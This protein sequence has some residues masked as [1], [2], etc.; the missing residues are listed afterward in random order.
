VR[1]EQSVFPGPRSPNVPAGPTVPAGNAGV[2]LPGLAGGALPQ[3]FASGNL[4]SQAPTRRAARRCAGAASGIALLALSGWLTGAHLLAGQWGRAIPM[5]PATAAAFL[6]LSA[7][8]FIHARWPARRLNPYVAPVSI[9]IPGL[10]GLLALA[11]FIGGFDLGLER[12]LAHTNQLLGGVP[13]GRMSPLAAAA[14]LLESGAL[15]LLLRAAR[16]RLAASVAALLALAAAAINAAIILGY[17]YGAPLL[18]GGSTIPVALPT[19]LAF[20]LVGAGQIMLALPAV[21]A[22]RAWSGDSMRG[23]LLRAF[24]PAIL[25]VI[26]LDGWLDSTFWAVAFV[27]HALWQSLTASV[28]CILIVTIIA[29]TARRTGDALERAKAESQESEARFR[30][31]FESAPV[32]Y[33]ELDRDGVVRRVNAAECALLGYQ[34]SEM[35][36]RAAWSLVAKA[37][38]EA[39]RAAVFRKLAGTQPLT[40]VRRR[41]RRRDGV[42]LLLEIHDRLVLSQVGEIQGLR[43]AFIDVTEV[44]RAEERIARQL[45]DLGAARDAQEK[46]GA[47]LAR[48]VEEL[49]LEKDRAQD[50]TRAKSE[51][52]ANMSHEIRTPMNG[53][54]GMTG[55][56]LD[57][58]LS[59]EQRGYAGIVR[60]SGESL[61]G[62]INDILDF[63][64]M[65]A[66]KLDL[67]VLDFCLQSLLDDFAATLGV[68][69]QEKGL[70]LCCSADPGVPTRLRGDPGRLRQILNNLVGNAVKFTRQGEVAVRVSLEEENETACLLRF[71]VRD[72]GI[73]I[74]ENKLGMVFAKFS[75]ADAS[76]TRNYGGTGLGLAI[77]QQL[78]ELMGGGVHVTSQEGQGSEFW[79]TASLG[80]QPEG[81]E[82]ASL[83]PAGLEG[84]RVLI[85]D[86]NAT[87]REIL[88]T[89]MT[90]WGMRPSEAGNGPEGIQALYGALAENDPIRVAV[91][92][93]QMPGMDGEAVGRAIRA[94][95]RLAGTRMVMLTPLGAQGDARRLAEIGFAGYATKPI[96]H[97][98]LSSVLAS[99]LSGAPGSSLRPMTRDSAREALHAFAGVH[100]RI[101]LAEDNIVN[102][103]VA[104]GVLKKFGLRADVVANGAEALQALKTIPYD[105]VLM[106]VQMPVM[107]GIE[108]TRQ[109]RH[110]QSK[111]RH[112]AIPIIAMTGHAM[113]GDRERCLEAGMDDYVSKPVSPQVLAEVLARWLPENDASGLPLAAKSP[114]PLPAPSIPVVFDRAGMLERLMNDEGLAKVITDGF[115]DDIPRQIEVLRGHLDAW[116]AP[117]AERLAHTIGGASSN[118]GGESLRALAFEMEKAGKAG[119]LGSVR[120]HM[121]DLAHE[122]LR[123]KEAIDGKP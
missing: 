8:V 10:L 20:L 102:Q 19:A 29:W 67:E 70:E 75:Q 48:L 41:Y 86:D 50:A 82:A 120:A 27:N 58:E 16:W 92:D 97:L 111:V 93:M 33:H 123:L 116:D 40:P 74:A 1:I 36:G 61:L 15:M 90:S 6:F 107:D 52:L 78:A 96:R 108:A 26:L 71:S 56:L 79:F 110:P 24:L 81:A 30:D 103:Q 72:T 95:R 51:F 69:A 32:A 46:H 9:G 42:E 35:L 94:D 73:G 106:D 55:L 3:P 100:A 34:A 101:L 98:E 31:L 21:P 12:W 84:V 91:I 7:G 83:P 62:I 77:S 99:A 122:F 115:L 87:N 37:D 39:S 49:A 54:I 64:R 104:L 4:D 17:C 18:Y 60:A 43:S 44:A 11:Q 59:E 113:Q 53:V 80:K 63:S 65:E 14:F 89:R 109:I 23:R 88:A 68:R 114:A 119:D 105:L 76:T 66:K 47:E 118:V 22:L 121:D 28:A 5:A 117:G 85:V 45:L 38:Q 112:H 25:L 2:A 13:L 57:T